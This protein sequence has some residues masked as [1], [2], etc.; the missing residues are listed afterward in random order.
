ME[1]ASIFKVKVKIS[2]DNNSYTV[3]VF[4]DIKKDFDKLSKENKLSLPFEEWAA[5]VC[6]TLPQLKHYKD[7]HFIYSWLEKHL[8]S[9]QVPLWMY[10]EEIIIETFAWQR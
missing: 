8:K 5:P 2:L 10:N 9:D 1:Q 6:L 4:D 3:D 7:N